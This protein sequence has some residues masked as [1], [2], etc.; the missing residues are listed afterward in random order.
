MIENVGYYLIQEMMQVFALKIQD[1]PQFCIMGRH[2]LSV[3]Y[4]GSVGLQEYEV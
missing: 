4:T 3:I 1:P 2:L